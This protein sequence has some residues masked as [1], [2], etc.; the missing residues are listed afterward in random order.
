M[1]SP[2]FRI[3]Y[4]LRPSVWLGLFGLLFLLDSFSILDWSHSWP[5]FIILIGVMM[6]LNRAPFL[7]PVPY[8]PASVAPVAT[9]DGDMT[10]LNLQ[11]DPPPSGS[12]SPSD[13]QTGG[14]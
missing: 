4:A 1:T 14:K 5:L 10:R 11:P 6:L 3:L 9:P 2:Q 13:H 8:S 12:D 7:A